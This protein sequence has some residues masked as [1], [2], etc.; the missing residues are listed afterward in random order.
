MANFH[1]FSPTNYINSPLINNFIGVEKVGGKTKRSAGKANKYISIAYVV[2][3]P[4]PRG[5]IP[6]SVCKC[7][8][9]LE[10]EIAFV[11]RV[12]DWRG[13]IPF[14]DL[15]YQ[16]KPKEKR[17]ERDSCSNPENADGGIK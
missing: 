10:A 5:G 17:N 13:E 7:K 9:H 2:R 16:R 8:T 4:N 1:D 12:P 14:R 11:E 6:I 15:S 3:I